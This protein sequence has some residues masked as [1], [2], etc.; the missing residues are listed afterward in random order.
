[1]FCSPREAA[2]VFSYQCAF[3]KCAADAAIGVDSVVFPPLYLY[4]H[5]DGYGVINRV[6][7]FLQASPNAALMTGARGCTPLHSAVFWFSTASVLREILHIRPTWV[8]IRAESGAWG[9][10][11]GG[12]PGPDRPGAT[13]R[14]SRLRIQV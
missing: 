6:R 10:G 13:F 1:M 4:V 7:T 9:E 8:S 11:V 12:R 14:G 5:S 2:P 3:P